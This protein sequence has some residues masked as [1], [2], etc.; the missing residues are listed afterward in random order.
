MRLSRNFS[1]RSFVVLVLGL[2]VSI[3]TLG[4]ILSRVSST[5]INLDADRSSFVEFRE[6]DNICLVGNV[7]AERLQ[8][9]GWLET[10]LQSRFPKLHL[11]FRNLG[12]AADEVAVRPRSEGFGTPD[13]HLA[14]QKADM[15]FVFF[16][17]N[18]SFAGE[19][20]RSKFKSDLQA[21][22]R[23]LKSQKY[24]GRTPPRII[25]F[26]PIAH[27]R[28]PDRNLPDGIANNQRLALYTAAVREISEVERVP[29]VDLFDLSQKLYAVAQEPLTTNGIHLSPRG[30]Q[31]LAAGIEQSLF[32]AGPQFKRD[33]RMLEKVRA[34]VIDKDFHWFHRYRTT[35]G[36]SSYGGRSYLTFVD[37]QSN[38]DVMFRELEVLDLMANNRDASIWGAANGQ[39]VATDD[40]KLPPF[41]KVKTNKPGTGPEGEH[42]FLNGEDAIRKMTVAPGMQV[43]LFADEKMFPELINPVQMA[44]DTRGRLWVAT[45]P[46]YP[47][48]RPRDPMDDRLL[49]LEDTD[50]DGKADTC[51]TFADNL[52]NPTGFE[53]WN[54]GVIIANAPDLLFLKDTDGDGKADVRQYL[55]HGLDSADTHHTANSFILDPGG[56]LYFQEGVFHRTQIETPYGPVRNIDACVWR[57]EPRTLKVDRYVSYGFANPHGHI[58]DRWGQDFVTDGTGAETFHATLFSG[59]ID[60]PRKHSRPPLVYEKRTRPCP[61]TE[62]LSSSHFPPENQGNLLVGNVI[63]FQGILQYKLSD[64]GASFSATE[65]DPV[66]YSSD[67]NFRPSD[68]EIGP[69]GA[70]WFIDWQNPIIGHMQHNLRDP[71]RDRVHGRV[72]RVTAVKRPLLKPV[73]IAGEPIHKLLDVLKSPEDRVRY[74]ARIELSGRNSDEVIAAVKPWIERLDPTRPDYQHQLLEA[75]WLHQSHNVVNT[76][77]LQKMLR[78]PDFHARAAATRVLCYWR[79]RVPQPFELL[80]TQINDAEPRVRLEAIRALSFFNDKQALEVAAELLAYAN[81][82]FL[83]Y[84][85]NETLAA[86]EMRLGTQVVR[87]HIATRL[88]RM[89]SEHR[90]ADARQPSV[91]ETICRYGGPSELQSVWETVQKLDGPQSQSALPAPVR[92]RLLEAL[93]DA[94][95]TRNARP[96]K[97]QASDVVRLMKSHSDARIAAQR[98]AVAWKVTAAADL[99]R[100]WAMDTKQPFDVRSTAIE[101]L[102]AFGDAGSLL[103]L[104]ELAATP[105][106]MPIRFLA[107]TAWAQKDLVA[108]AGAAATALSAAGP[109]DDVVPVVQSFLVR[110]NGAAALGQALEQQHASAD[111]ARRVLRAM[112]LAGRNDPA[113]AEPASRLAGVDVTPKRPT[114]AEVKQLVIQIQAE[115]DAARGELIFRRN[116]L[117]CIQCHALNKAGGN[118]GPDLGPLGGSSP[119]DYIVTSILDPNQAVKEEYLTKVV[120]TNAGKMFSGIVVQRD[121]NQVVLKDATGKR[122]RI[123]VSEIDEEA[124]GPSLM[125]EGITRLLPRAE[126]LDL[127]KFISEL[128]KPGRFSAGPVPT[129]RRWKRLRDVP[130]SLREGVPNREIFRETISRMLPEKWDRVYSLVDGRLPLDELTGSGIGSPVWLQGEFR[131]TQRGPLSVHLDAGDAAAISVWIGEELHNQATVVPI[132][133]PLGR[134]PITIRIPASS[135]SRSASHRFLKVEIQKPEGSKAQVEAIQSD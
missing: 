34:A 104:K 36:Y 130:P 6:G 117:G 99:L 84:T 7:L 4:V 39:D 64:K 2:G 56:S 122:V 77:L 10:L 93:A 11:R 107:V 20:G 112:F 65:V 22:V 17:F 37:G 101:S 25:L 90:I 3:P 15:V 73:A 132:D 121:K 76:E 5:T 97:I 18:E 124:N 106:A 33:A 51:H 87:Q 134:H 109:A 113:L 103:A 108:A 123:P 14:R 12:F 50:G 79:D 21:Y 119:V 114:P 75:L 102:S 47:H 32:P 92:S 74:R 135:G 83:R 53:F 48:W 69:D 78:S 40:S 59:S 57:F 35:D 86:L 115:G 128:G 30:N 127:M 88:V 110:K 9:D 63:G 60:Y 131:I 26:S 96:A 68:L 61:G 66:V 72:Y 91:M 71:S 125:P 126:L 80:R 111:A 95:V 23:H 52:H 1:V 67:P 41:L 94:A 55:L 129:I 118:V 62:I 29:F 89:L 82:D 27:E 42:N 81:D 13:E 8:H 70:I 116:D 24:N 120:T 38:R 44:F 31:L 85:F 100:R 28:F 49:I 19:A 45:W 58:F 46:S 133:L 54:G 16:G 43:S 105:H 98:L